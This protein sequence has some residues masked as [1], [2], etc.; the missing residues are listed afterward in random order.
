MLTHEYDIVCTSI[1]FL[2]PPIYVLILLTTQLAQ[3]PLHPL[4]L[5]GHGGIKPSRP[6][7][8]LWCYFDLVHP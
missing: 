4:T 7:K 6:N 8:L 5:F 2:C 1:A 3:I